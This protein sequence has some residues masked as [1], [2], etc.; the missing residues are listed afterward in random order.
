MR[1]DLTQAQALGVGDAIEGDG[2][3][4]VSGAPLS[5]RTNKSL[6]ALFVELL[7]P[8]AWADIQLES[9]TN[10]IAWKEDGSI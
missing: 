5:L 3:T 9:L 4:V 7:I 1:V 10:V 2:N 8:K 6:L